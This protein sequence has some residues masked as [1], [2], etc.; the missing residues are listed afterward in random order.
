MKR[1]I[2]IIVAFL[3]TAS[4]AVS[5]QEKTVLTLDECKRIALD[6]NNEMKKA[7]LD[8]VAAKA[9]KKEIFT[10][11]FPKVSMLGAAM[12]SLDYNVK[13]HV[14][15]L[16]GKGD[17]GYDMEAMWMEMAPE[18]GANP[19]FNFLK[20][21]QRYG[22]TA[23]QPVFAGG[24][25]VNGNKYAALGIK[26]AR[27]KGD[28]TRRNTLEEVEKNYF[29]VIAL[30]EKGKTL[31]CLQ[32]MLDSLEKAADI[33]V[34]EG[35]ILRSDHMLLQTKKMELAQGKQ[36]LR[37]GIKLMKMNLLNGI[38]YDYRVYQLDSI[39]LASMDATNLPS[40][41]QVYVDEEEAASRTEESQLLELQIEAK[42]FEKKLTVGETL[43]QVGLGVIY[44]YTR[45][46]EHN[47][48]RLNGSV[49]A[50]VQIPISDWAKNSFKMQRQQV[51]IDKAILDRDYLHK[52]LVLQ[53]RK[54]YFD[55]TSAW[56]ALELARTQQDYN[57]CLY[58]QA[59]VN[60]EAGYTTVTDMLQAYSTLS[61]SS[62]NY[63]SAL[64]AYLAA[65]Q[66]Y[67]GRLNQDKK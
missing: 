42:R 14:T 38:G 10:N 15:D 41:E 27:L 60:F 6:S 4:L 29:D 53:Q 11:Y 51:D 43:P 59:K 24:R 63:S 64:S 3:A 30:K 12:H 46:S 2:S 54:L 58:N 50:M 1:R 18:F 17:L 65:L 9:Q 5:A 26:A 47:P 66:I 20:Y 45:L 56:D 35:V 57:Q 7:N 67:T 62:E 32:Q 34:K 44:G 19:S 28:I 25:I 31:D 13:V 36:K 37:T 61:E 52:M 8:V 49:F 48:G 21:V 33:A 40:P 55:L 22:A 39:D 16:L 23:I